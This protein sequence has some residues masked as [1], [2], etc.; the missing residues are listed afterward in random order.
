MYKGTI[1][2]RAYSE[3]IRLFGG[4]TE[5]ANALEASARNVVY[6]WRDTSCPNAH[7]LSKLYSAGADIKYILTGEKENEN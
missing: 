3:C 2:Q 6:R 7:F 5:A 1:G 4:V